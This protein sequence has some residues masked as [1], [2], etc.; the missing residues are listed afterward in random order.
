M[1]FAIVSDGTRFSGR[2]AN[3]V[4]GNHKISVIADSAG[5]AYLDAR[6]LFRQGLNIG[7][8]IQNVAAAGTIGVFGTLSPSE[9]ATRPSTRTTT[10][11]NWGTILVT[12]NPGD[13]FT[14]SPKVY[15]AFKL[16]FSAAGEAVFLTL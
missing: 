16:V 2:S 12:L 9:L 14:V 7:P 15:S 3:R 10:Q 8:T 11:V 6:T 5:T 1:N 13:T 4:T